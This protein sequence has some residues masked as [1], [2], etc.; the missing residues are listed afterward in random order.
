[1]PLLLSCG[2]LF[3]LLASCSLVTTPIKIV[4]KTAATTL[5]IA[6]MA[7]ETGIDAVSGG[8]DDD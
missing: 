7:A 2:S 6:G 1:M 5:G 8:H 3:F 4:G